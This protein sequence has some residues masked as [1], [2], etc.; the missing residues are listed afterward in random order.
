ML[1]RATLRVAILQL[2]QKNKG[3]IKLKL[4]EKMYN[5]VVDI[6]ECYLNHPFVNEMAAGTLPTEKF[7]N[8]MLQDYAYL[9][10]YVK[11]FACCLL[12]SNTID[13]I[14]FFSKNI[15]DVMSEID[16]VHVPN[17]KKLGIT[18]REIKSV[19]PTI[20]NTSYSHFMICEAEMG[21][22]LTCLVSL[23]CCSWTYAFIGENMVKKYPHALNNKYGQWFKGYTCKEYIDTNNDL[24]NRVDEMSKDIS[25]EKVEGLCKLF[26]KCS[27]YE[28]SFWNMLYNL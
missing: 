4:S 18:D 21:D 19:V 20:E 6:W 23:L 22:L 24:I 10:D 9:K 14:R 12:K 16:R 13:D 7:H 1:L 15:E 28:L 8:Y 5:S 11:I 2:L 27:E 3:V 17:M 26:R 25:D